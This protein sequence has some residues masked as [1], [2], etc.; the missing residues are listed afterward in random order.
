M[1]ATNVSQT[2]LASKICRHFGRANSRHVA[3]NAQ[4][5]LSNAQKIGDLSEEGKKLLLASLSS[6]SQI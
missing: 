3:N 6:V 4:L 2:C 1:A 5:N